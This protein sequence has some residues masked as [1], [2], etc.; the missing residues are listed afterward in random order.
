MEGKKRTRKPNWTEEQCLLLAQL[1]EEN[2]GV[3]RRKFGSRITAQA[4]RQ[5]WERIARRISASFPLLLRTSNECEKRWYVLQSKTRA[6]VAAHKRASSQSEGGSPAKQLSQVSETV[7]G[8]LEKSETSNTR[9]KE[10]IDGSL[11]QLVELPQSSG[12]KDE[13]EPSTSLAHA[14]PE[15][16]PAPPPA[17]S[18]TPSLLEKKLE[19][20]I[21]VLMQQKKVLSLREEYYRLKIEHLK[22]KLADN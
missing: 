1:V 17:P 7:S 10:E 12:P 6:V 4:K 13:P 2:K 14:R 9:L 18:P 5:T 16:A 3:L 15:T 8:V 20:E 11:I 19:A 22:N 21:D